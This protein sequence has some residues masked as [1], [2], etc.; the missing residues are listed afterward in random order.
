MTLHACP[1]WTI[2]SIVIVPNTAINAS[3]TQLYELLSP[4]A[5]GTGVAIDPVVSMVELDI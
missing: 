2:V 3:H 4:L 5:L 1:S